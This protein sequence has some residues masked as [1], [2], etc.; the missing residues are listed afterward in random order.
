MRDKIMR[1]K[2]IRFF[3]KSYRRKIIMRDV[4][5]ET[6]QAHCSR[7]DTRRAGIWFDGYDED[8]GA[9]RRAARREE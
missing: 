1:Y 8:K 2:I 4:S 6:A 7:D 5:L 9:T 3:K